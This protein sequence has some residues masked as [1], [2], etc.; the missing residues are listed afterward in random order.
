M[1]A[2]QHMTTTFSFFP[3]PSQ[4]FT[5]VILRNTKAQKKSK[6]RR[7]RQ[8]VGSFNII[9][10]I[11]AIKEC[12]RIEKVEFENENSKSGKQGKK[13]SAFLVS[14][15]ILWLSSVHPKGFEIENEENKFRCCK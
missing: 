6:L 2:V 8:V 5:L 10:N 13:L 4:G 14:C 7:K 11:F 12:S 1:I 9:P 15:K 3:L